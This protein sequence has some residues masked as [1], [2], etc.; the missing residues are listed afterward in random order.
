MKKIWIIPAKNME[1]ASKKSPYK[2]PHCQGVNAF[3]PGLFSIRLLL[4][5]RNYAEQWDMDVF[6]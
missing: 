1:M 3:T 4:L 5:F 6:F 2:I